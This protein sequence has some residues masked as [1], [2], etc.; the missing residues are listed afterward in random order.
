MNIKNDFF[1]QLYQLSKLDKTE[2][3]AS[4]KKLE[5]LLELNYGDVYAD[6]CIFI[7]KLVSL[8]NEYSQ[9]YQLFFSFSYRIGYI[10]GVPVLVLIREREF[11]FSDIFITKY[12]RTKSRKY[13]TVPKVWLMGS[14]INE[15]SN[16]DILL[17][18]V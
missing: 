14:S 18:G 4:R 11:P 3:Y 6:D 15:M 17:G 2:F 5:K 7:K 8:L 10:K 16:K 9:V 13:R 12:S 1:V